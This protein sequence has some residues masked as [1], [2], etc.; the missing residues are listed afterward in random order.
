MKCYRDFI[1]EA[2]SAANAQAFAK[3]KGKYYSSSDGKTYAN[4]GAARA[5]H[6]SR[7]KDP[8]IANSNT[9][10]FVARQTAVDKDYKNTLNKTPTALYNPKTGRTSTG[11]V[12]LLKGKIVYNVTGVGPTKPPRAE[13]ERW[14][15]NTNNFL[16]RSLGG[17]TSFKGGGGTAALDKLRK[18][19]PNASALNIQARGLDALRRREQTPNTAQGFDTA[20]ASARKLGQKTFNWRGGSYTTDVA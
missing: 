5:A 1:L 6:N 12:G 4:Y 16:S 8:T 18:I 15:A 2:S 9:Q 3:S 13:S 20:F 19:K 17:E 11:T 14:R 7:L 10:R